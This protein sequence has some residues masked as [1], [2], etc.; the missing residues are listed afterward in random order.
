MLSDASV[1]PHKVD[2]VHVSLCVCVCMCF[3]KLFL[4]SCMRY[5]IQ[6]K[7]LQIFELVH[8]H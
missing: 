3:T 7:I 4:Q 5:D 6:S 8:K 1:Q 2:G